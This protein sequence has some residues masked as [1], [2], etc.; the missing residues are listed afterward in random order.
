MQQHAGSQAVS[1][2]MHCPAANGGRI[3]LSVSP[4]VGLWK[5]RYLSTLCSVKPHLK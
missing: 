4:A 1:R 5:I 3:L 2:I